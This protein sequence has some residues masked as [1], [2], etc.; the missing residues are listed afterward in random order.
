MCLMIMKRSILEVQSASRFL[1]EIDQ[2]FP[3]NK[4][5]E[6]SNLLA[7]LISMKYKRKGNIREYIMEMSNLATKLKSLKLKLSEDLIVHLVLISFF[8]HFGQFKVSYNTL[9][10]KWSPNELISHRVQEERRL[11]KDKT[12]S[13]HFVSTSQNKKKNFKSSTNI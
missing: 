4:K 2:F 13:A 8:A 6:T 9:K 3:K 12:K 11:Q 1:E 10:D 5:A 7:K